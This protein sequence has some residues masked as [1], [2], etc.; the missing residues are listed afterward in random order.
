VGVRPEH[1]DI[2]PKDGTWT[3]KVIYSENLGSDSYI[4]VD[5]GATDPIIVRQDGKSNYHS[6][7]QLNFSPRGEHFYRFDE[8]GRPL[9][10]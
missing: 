3:G 1:F 10:H 5:I 2:V 6:G 8:A 7:D 4:Y 9:V